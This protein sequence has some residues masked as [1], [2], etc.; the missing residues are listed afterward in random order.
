MISHFILAKVSLSER[1]MPEG[2]EDPPK[3]SGSTQKLICSDSESIGT[4]NIADLTSCKKSLISRF[5]RS[6]HVKPIKVNKTNF[7]L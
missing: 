6:L 4:L 3:L 1:G 2:Q 7:H 5:I